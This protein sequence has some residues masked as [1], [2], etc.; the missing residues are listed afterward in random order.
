[1]RAQHRRSGGRA[2]GCETKDIATVEQVH[3]LSPASC[4]LKHGHCR[5]AKQSARQSPLLLYAVR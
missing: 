2:G 4:W 5:T 1:L 3:D